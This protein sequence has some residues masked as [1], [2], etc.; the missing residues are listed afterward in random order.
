MEVGTLKTNFKQKNKGKKSLSV[1]EVAE[2]VQ[3]GGGDKTAV[4]TTGRFLQFTIKNEY[5]SNFYDVSFAR[6]FDDVRRFDGRVYRS[7]DQRRTRMAT[8]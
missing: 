2:T 1:K 6:R 8:F 7:G 3:S 5:R 4:M